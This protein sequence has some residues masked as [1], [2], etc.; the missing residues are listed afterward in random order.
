MKE[1][2]SQQLAKLIVKMFAAAIIGSYKLVLDGLVD[3]ALIQD[4]DIMVFDEKEAD[5]IRIYLESM[6]YE[7][8]KAP[9]DKPGYPRQEGSLMFKKENSVPIHLCITKENER[10]MVWFDEKWERAWHPEDSVWSTER[11]LGTKILR[12]T[13]SDIAQIRH[14]LVDKEEEL[15]DLQEKDK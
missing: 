13:E 14:I 3:S 15:M 8:S 11:I 7:E 6:G 12:G 2:I 4:I 5:K 9:V 1:Y 10:E